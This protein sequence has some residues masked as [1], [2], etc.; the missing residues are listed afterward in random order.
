[1]ID[2]SQPT[3]GGD[4]VLV[5]LQFRRA[6][7]GDEDSLIADADVAFTVE[8]T[9]DA[10]TID[11][12]VPGAAAAWEERSSGDEGR[13]R[14][15]RTPADAHVHATIATIDSAI[16]EGPAE[17]RSLIVVS[18]PAATVLTVR[19]RLF[20]IGE[21][22][23]GALCVLLGC[24]VGLEVERRQQVLAFVASQ[25]TTHDR[26]ATV[27][28]G[29]GR[30]E[31]GR[32][33]EWDDDRVV[34]DNFGQTIRTTVGN[35]VSVVNVRA[36]S[37]PLSDTLDTYRRDM[38]DRNARPTWEHLIVALGQRFA[39]GSA[40]S[41]DADVWT[42]DPGTVAEAVETATKEGVS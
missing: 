9:D 22:T 18:S 41:D 34:I 8:T 40:V 24:S 2:L 33:V 10:G 4:G 36:E 30:L 23:A 21:T 16:Y 7:R 3:S 27:R 15:T 11:G 32:V 42:L 13:S 19:A 39:E 5:K 12:T 1:M 29:D 14:L 28:C 35:V 20:D 26:I 37:G 25:S 17:L 31:F 6:G 38:T